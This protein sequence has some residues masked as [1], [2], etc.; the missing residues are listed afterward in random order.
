M[1]LRLLPGGRL[2]AEGRAAMPTRANRGPAQDRASLPPDGP[3]LGEG[4][5]CPRLPVESGGGRR[6]EPD[7]ARAVVVVLEVDDE[8]SLVHMLVKINRGGAGDRDGARP[9]GPRVRPVT[10]RHPFPA[11]SAM[12]RASLKNGQ[13]HE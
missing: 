9:P 1:A 3:R 7:V 8:S 12:Y 10:T 5:A 2:P 11:A 13:P 4:A 6:G